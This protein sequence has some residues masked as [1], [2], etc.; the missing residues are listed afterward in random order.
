MT[1]SAWLGAKFTLVHLTDLHITAEEQGRARGVE[2]ASRLRAVVTSINRLWPEPSLA[3]I[4]GDFSVRGSATA[5]RRAAELLAPIRIPVCAALGNHDDPETFHAI[6]GPLG[7]AGGGEPCHALAIQ[8]WRILLLNSKW[9][10][11]KEGFL[12]PEQRRR[13][14]EELERHRRIPTLLFTHHHVV[15]L[16][17]PWVDRDNMRDWHE[18]LAMLR[19]AGDVRAVFS[20]HA[21]QARHHSW[22][23]IPFFVTPSTGYQFARDVR[24]VRVAWNE[25]PAYRVIRVL[26]DLFFTE[27][28]PVPPPAEGVDAAEPDSVAT[29]GR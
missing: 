14:Q 8:G 13:V 2:T 6:M 18:F 17:L 29:D 26:G 24:E 21:H 12:G 20:G 28:R 3:V 11:V 5:Y 7:F 22:G 15:P 4:T 27:I 23:G 9:S 25:P 10:G 1:P 16:G 19:D